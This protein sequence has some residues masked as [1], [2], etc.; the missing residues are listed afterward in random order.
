MRECRPAHGAPLP[1]GPEGPGGVASTFVVGADGGGTGSRALVMDLQGAILGRA[2][3]PPALIDPSNPEA[4]AEAIARTVR[5]ALTEAELHP[6][7]RAL[8]TGLAGAGRAGTREAVEIA[9]R[10]RG[11]ASETRVGM[12]VEG[13]HFDAFGDEAGVLLAVG[14]GSVVWARD[15]GGRE[16][17]VGGWGSRLGEEGS[18]YWLGMEGLRAL[19]RA[20]DGRDPP[21][22]L[23]QALLVAL[24]LSGFWDLIPWVAQA[25]KAEVAALAP[26]VL[27]AAAAGDPAACRILGE[28]LEA[29][30]GHLD[31]VRAAWDPWGVPFPLALSGGLLEEGAP[32]R[33]A[34]LKMAAQRGAE[35]RPDPVVPA[36]GAARLALSLVPSA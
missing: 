1:E 12:D 35:I 13:A 19:A 10:S 25:S 34:A 17:K 22:A 20:H 26:L 30:G 27:A 11:L 5:A 36:R 29:L 16:M 23:T 3:G 18:G 4:A 15:P 9:L 6:P 2:H 32:L 24:R 31:V 7:A 28:G 21:T 33:P 8:W 14:T